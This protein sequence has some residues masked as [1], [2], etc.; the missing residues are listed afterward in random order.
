MYDFNIFMYDF[1]TGEQS[2]FPSH[3]ISCG[4]VWGS[5]YTSYFLPPIKKVL[6]PLWLLVKWYDLC[7]VLPN[8]SLE[9]AMPPL[10]KMKYMYNTL[11]SP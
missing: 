10:P 9:E 6:P 5:P 1:T 8:E 2:V 3:G 4:M 11:P 7:V